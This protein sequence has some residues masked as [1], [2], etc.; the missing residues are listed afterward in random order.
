MVYDE[1]SRGAEETRLRDLLAQIRAGRDAT[2]SPMVDAKLRAME[3][4]CLHALTFFTV[5]IDLHPYLP[6]LESA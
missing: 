6:A 4:L 5:E 2:D 1:T 3:E